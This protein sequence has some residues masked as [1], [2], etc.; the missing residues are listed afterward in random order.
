MIEMEK[1]AAKWRESEEK[2][3][4]LLQKHRK[5]GTI[6]VESLHNDAAKLILPYEL[7]YLCIQAMIDQKRRNFIANCEKAA[8]DHA[9]SLVLYRQ[10]DAEDLVKGNID[11][12]DRTVRLKCTSSAIWLR[13]GGKVFSLF[14]D[15][16]L[17]DENEHWI[18]ETIKFEHGKLGTFHIKVRDPKERRKTMRLNKKAEEERKQKMK[19]E[20]EAAIAKARAIAKGTFKPENIDETV[21]EGK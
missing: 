18:T 13:G 7:K 20:Q 15:K 2:M 9:K 4:E 6:P 11:T 12:L 8:A 10:S 5:A 16:R 14:S 1:Q 19:A 21:E 17:G 3:D